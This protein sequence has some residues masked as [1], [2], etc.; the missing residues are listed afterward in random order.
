[1]A[2]Y[3]EFDFRDMFSQCG[4]N[5]PSNIISGMVRCPEHTD[6]HPS[7]SVDVQAG[8]YHC[9]SCGMSG[10][11]V[12][13]Y[14]QKFGQLYQKESSSRNIGL[15][16]FYTRTPSNN[17]GI[18]NILSGPEIR[19]TASFREYLDKTL[20]KNW[21]AYRGINLKV[22]TAS[23]VNYGIVDINYTN[24]KG[25][26]LNYS[27]EG[28]IIFPVYN[29]KGKLSSI[30]M[31]YPFFAGQSDK[32]IK[33][34]L[35]PKGSSTN[36]LYEEFKLD[37]K[38]KLYVLEGLMDCLAFRSLTGIQNST[39]IFG[40]NLTKLQLQKLNKF[41]EVCYVYNNDGPGLNSVQTLFEN[42]K[43][44]F[45]VLAPSGTFDDVGEMA[46]SKFQEVDKWMKQET[47]WKSLQKN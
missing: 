13:L 21:L 6:N 44:K 39:S 17:D 19:F 27:V 7:M 11:I 33:K 41:P 10:H 12:K 15:T 36:M 32:T 8:I 47:T 30:E 28:R 2:N 18:Q 3:D 14:R 16:K 26:K 1:M 31:R 4:F 43:G 46:I 25:E 29:S 45:T 5:I 34:C 23:N 22:A 37:S 38:K 42:Y 9:F 20:L 35:Y 24:Q 40:A